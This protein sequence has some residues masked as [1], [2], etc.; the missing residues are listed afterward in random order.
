MNQE[1][2]K[3]PIFFGALFV[4]VT[5]LG[6]IISRMDS[7]ALSGDIH[8]STW[9]SLVNLNH[10]AFHSWRLEPI[11]KICSEIWPSFNF[12][13]RPIPGIVALLVGTLLFFRASD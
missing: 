13:E 12:A 3:L 1:Q 5:V 6:L 11:A 9:F 4:A 10:N 7:L 8:A 2:T